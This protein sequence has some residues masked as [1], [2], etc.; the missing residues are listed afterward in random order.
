MHDAQLA[1]LARKARCHCTYWILSAHAELPS[2]VGISAIAS[3]LAS[4]CSTSKQDVATH[5]KQHRIF[6]KGSDVP[7]PLSHFEQLEALGVPAA[8]AQAVSATYERPSAIQVQ[9]QTCMVQASALHGSGLSFAWFRPQPC[10]IPPLAACPT[11]QPPVAVDASHP[12]HFD[13]P[14]C[15]WRC[16]YRLRQDPG[17]WHPCLEPARETSCRRLSRLRHCSNARALPTGQ[18][19]A[20]AVSAWG[21]GSTGDQGDAELQS[22][23]NGVGLDCSRTG[24]GQQASQAAN[25]PSD[26]GQQRVTEDQPKTRYGWSLLRACLHGRACMGLQASRSS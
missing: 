16:P 9:P 12:R 15:P 11:S 7:P 22:L 14:G 4:C 18:G 8:L 25:P 20:H 21:R 3:Y 10:A 5:R 23:K 24:R 1:Q 26:Q 13:P 19:L 17:L 6:V 2:S